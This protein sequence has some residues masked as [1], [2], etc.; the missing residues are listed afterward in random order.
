MAKVIEGTR[1]LQS[2]VVCPHC[3]HSYA[4]EDSLWV[5]QHPD[6]IGDE[7]LGSDQQQRFL[8]TRFSP[9]GD[10]IDARGFSCH[11]I[12]CPRCHLTVPWALLELESQFLSILGSPASGK[13]YFLAAMTWQLRKTLSSQFSLSFTDADPAANRN[14]NEYEE[15][16]FLNPNPDALVAI[17][18]TELQGELYDVVQFGDQRIN[19]PR[20]FVF[21]LRPL[22][23]H[24]AHEQGERL[25]RG[26]C[27]YDNA[28][29]HFQPGADTIGSPATRHLA[30]SRVLFFVFDPTQDPR[31]RAAC[32]ATTKDPQMRD[33]ARTFRQETVLLEAADRVRRYGGLTHGAKH[34]RPLV[35]IVTKYDAWS[36]LLGPDRLPDEWAIRK[37]KSALSAM[38]LGAVEHVS[39]HV[40]ELLRRHAPEVVSA[41]EGFASQVI[42]I[43]V[44]A[45]GSAPQIDPRTGALC[46]QPRNI[47]PM[48][49]EIP[50]AY[51]LSR[52][53]GGLIPF[54]NPK[55]TQLPPLEMHHTSTNRVAPA[56]PEVHTN[57]EAKA[58]GRL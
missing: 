23:D 9:E 28:G 15:L 32:E 21:A 56:Q 40:R 19:Y 17:R 47:R 10:A 58:K 55:F 44:S 16:L 1:R 7:R 13:S 2:P 46:V 42:Y 36:N 45:L 34:Q 38:D 49:V 43:P 57:G 51:A 12:A 24:P 30:L 31:F 3:W 41:A 25:A 39:K 20:P 4:P 18:K 54:V 29:E 35:V 50:M 26:V 53:A 48:W 5:S 11:A 14:L 33:R 52:W 27:L 37:G 6:L 8:P 22:A